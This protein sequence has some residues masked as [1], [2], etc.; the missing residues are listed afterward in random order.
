MLDKIPWVM[1]ETLDPAIDPAVVSVGGDPRPF[2]PLDRVIERL[3]KNQSIPASYNKMVRRKVRHAI[4]EVRQNGREFDSGD[5]PVSIGSVHYRLVALPVPG[6]NGGVHAVQFWF[7]PETSPRHHPKERRAAGVVWDL[8]KQ[9]IAQ[10]IESQRLSGVPDDEYFPEVSLAGIFDR[11]SQF[12]QHDEVIRLL[13]NPEPGDRLQFEVTVPHMAGTLMQWQVTIRARDDDQCRGAWWMWEDIT[14]PLHPPRHPTLEQIGYRAIH[15]QAG[16]HAAVVMIAYPATICYWLTEAAPW[17]RWTFLKKPADVFHPEDRAALNM[18]NAELE[19]GKSAEVV[20]RTLSPDGD[21]VRTRLLLSPYPGYI[22]KGMMIGQ[23]LRDDDDR[24][25]IPLYPTIVSP[26][27]IGHDEQM[28]RHSSRWPAV[29][30][31]P[32]QHWSQAVLP[33]II[34][35]EKSDDEPGQDAPGRCK[36]RSGITADQRRDTGRGQATDLEPDI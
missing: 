5:N 21:Y 26:Q 23:F 35:T 14:S 36:G 22:G 10:P 15:R 28:R 1:V 3:L 11:A 20:V 24:S 12:D 18:L 33:E 2:T 16:T 13:Y 9:V 25:H 34:E 30:P 4:E 8:D 19:I 7:G 29:A 17:I 31:T 32:G 27:D 6:P